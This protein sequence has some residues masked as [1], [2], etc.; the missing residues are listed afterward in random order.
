MDERVMHEAGILT[1]ATWT[2]V[3]HRDAELRKKV[4]RTLVENLPDQLDESL[5]DYEKE[6]HPS[7][8]INVMSDK[9]GVTLDDDDG[10][11][12]QCYINPATPPTLD[13]QFFKRGWT[14]ESGTR[15]SLLL[16]C[17]GR[18][19]YVW[20]APQSEAI[21]SEKLADYILRNLFSEALQVIKSE[22]QDLRR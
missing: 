21:P 22:T 15:V 18:D 4:F 8:S 20:I 2:K 3:F 7:Q 11:V 12:V 9:T 17:R 14:R 19:K 5:A 6:L 13:L 16:E 10:S 1:A